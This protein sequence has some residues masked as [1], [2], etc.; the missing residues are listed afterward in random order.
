MKHVILLFIFSLACGLL[1]AQQPRLPHVAGYIDATGGVNNVQGAVGESL[2]YNL[3]ETLACDDYN[4]MLDFPNIGD[5][6]VREVMPFG[7]SLSALS[8]VDIAKVAGNMSVTGRRKLYNGSR[9]SAVEYSLCDSVVY[10]IKLYFSASD[11]TARDFVVSQC[12]NFFGKAD[13][14]S[15]TMTVF[16]DPDYLVKV[17]KDAVDAY[18]LYHY[19]GEEQRFPGVQL[20]KWKA[21]SRVLADGVAVALSF[22][23]QRTKENNMQ[24]AFE[25]EIDAAEPLGMKKMIFVA[26][27]KPYEYDVESDFVDREADMRTFM[28]PDDVKHILRSHTLTVIIECANGRRIS[29]EM[30]YYQ[31]ASLSTAFTYFKWNVTNPMMKYRGW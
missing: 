28:F 17:G 21:P 26:D 5:K 30:P 11:A 14:D 13:F 25:I 24:L 6:G 22:Y 1:A 12:A 19:P 8:Q 20:F 31:R 4:L 29:Y 16:S 15:D 23:N 9:F 27:G 10:G 2:R 18:S 3:L 7:Y